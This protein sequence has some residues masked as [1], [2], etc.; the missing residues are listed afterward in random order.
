MWQCT[1]NSKY[2]VPAST[3]YLVRP[4]FRASHINGY[5]ILS[6]RM[7]NGKYLTVC[8]SK[9]AHALAE[10]EDWGTFVCDSD[11]DQKRLAFSTN[12]TCSVC[13]DAIDDEKNSFLSDC[14]HRFHRSC[15]L[16]AWK[17]HSI[18]SWL[19]LTSSLVAPPMCGKLNRIRSK[20]DRWRCFW[21]EAEEDTGSKVADREDN[22]EDG[23]GERLRS[24][25]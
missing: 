9:I 17:K 6:R 19:A 4:G 25:W 12:D 22:D 8:A 1:L 23:E 3:S 11:V 14:G 10:S 5:R 20:R 15:V 24:V 16:H 7:N 13:L 21:E 18:I 2:P